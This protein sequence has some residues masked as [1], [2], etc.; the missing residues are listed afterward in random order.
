M[1]TVLLIDADSARCAALEPQI[2]ALRNQVI[3]APTGDEG[4][5]R[6]SDNSVD[7]VV[8]SLHLPDMAGVE[9][10]DLARQFGWKQPVIVLATE[11][12]MEEALQSW[13]RGAIACLLGS[14]DA[15]AVETV[16]RQAESAC[17]N[18]T[19][20]SRRLH[21]LRSPMAA[22]IMQLEML[23]NPDIMLDDTERCA[24]I[25]ATVNKSKCLLNHIDSFY[26]R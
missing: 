22:I 8:L 19:A 13:R 15:P 6:W 20:L 21:D 14:V 11:E 10:F 2:S 18:E 3:L 7:I 17:T 4:L 1:S 9:V 25:A 16:L 26:R 23:S 5:R 24:L 12:E